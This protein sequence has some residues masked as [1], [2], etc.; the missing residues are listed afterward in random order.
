MMFCDVP[1]RPDIGE[2]GPGPSVM[3]PL[4]RQ[5]RHEEIAAGLSLRREMPHFLDQYVRL[6]FIS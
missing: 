4:V 1:L 3:M 6:I 5:R 2:C